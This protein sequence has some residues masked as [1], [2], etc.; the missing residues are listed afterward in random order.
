L[1]GL[2]GSTGVSGWWVWDD[3]GAAGGRD[4]GGEGGDLLPV[5]RVGSRTPAGVGKPVFGDENG[6][7]LALAD[8]APCEVVDAGQPSEGPAVRDIDRAEI[9]Q[10]GG[11]E[12]TVGVVEL[13]EELGGLDRLEDQGGDPPGQ[14]L[15]SGPPVARESELG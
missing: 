7:E 11:E 15:G 2:R 3:F 13:A 14:E 12:G 8:H 10:L 1:L 6:E 9:G 5:G 4:R